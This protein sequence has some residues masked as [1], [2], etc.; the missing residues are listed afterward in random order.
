MELLNNKQMRMLELLDGMISQCKDCTLYNG[1]RVKPHWTPMSVFAGL[2]E[3][4]GKDEVE[5]NEPF[6]GKAG[7]ILGTSMSKQGFRKE[8]F[9]IINS[10]NCRPVVDGKNGKPTMDQ[11]KLCHKWVRKYIKVVNP[12]KIIAFGNYA[13]GSLNGIYSGIIKNNGLV[14]HNGLFNKFVIYSVHP[15]YSIYNKEDGIPM[16]DRSIRIFKDMRSN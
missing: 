9:L 8:Q 15:A 13:R 12:E 6:V 11:I 10:V 4:P 14:E 2:G 1:G 16:L 3:A 5:E 7:D